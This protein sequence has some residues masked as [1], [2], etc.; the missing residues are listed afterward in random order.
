MRE[1]FASTT[2]LEVTV[3]GLVLLCLDW[4]LSHLIDQRDQRLPI[5]A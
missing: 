3:A 4:S 1:E 2:F 5:P